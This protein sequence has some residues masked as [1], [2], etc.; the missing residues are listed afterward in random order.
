M[1][2]SGLIHKVLVREVEWA[3][4]RALGCKLVKRGFSHLCPFLSVLKTPLN[5]KFRAVCFSGQSAH[6]FHL[7]CSKVPK[8]LYTSGWEPLNVGLGS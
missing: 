5:S 2:K 3:Q 4:E 6:S 7:D 8:S 1:W